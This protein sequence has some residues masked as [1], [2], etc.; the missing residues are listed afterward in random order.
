MTGSVPRKRSCRK[1]SPALDGGSS[2]PLVADQQ[3]HIVGRTL[4]R[5]RCPRR[6]GVF[7]DVGECFLDDPVRGQVDAGGIWSR[8]PEICR[9]TGTPEAR[10]SAI[11]SGSLRNDGIGA[12]EVS[13]S[14]RRRTFSIRRMSPKPGCWCVRS[15]ER[16]TGRAVGG[17]HPTAPA[18]L[19]QRHRHSVRHDIMK[20]AGDPGPLGLQR[21]QVS[22]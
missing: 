22:R 15:L 17:Q 13:P 8:S 19:H 1:K 9:S 18:R 16:C 3:R 5:D 14:A 12:V 20:I 2:V 21:H 10:T 7:D 4:D 11:S 6:P